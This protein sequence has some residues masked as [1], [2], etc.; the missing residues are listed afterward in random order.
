MWLSPV[1]A[2]LKNIRPAFRLGPN[3]DSW[4]KP[5]ITLKGILM[6]KNKPHLLIED[7]VARLIERGLVVKDVN[8]A[9]G[10]LS[11]IGYYRLNGYWH[12]FY[13]SDVGADGRKIVT[14]LFIPGV[15]FDQI[16]DIYKFDEE[17]RLLVFKGVSQIEVAIRAALAYEVGSS[18]PYG[19]SDVVNFRNNFKDFDR[20]S[21]AINA[22]VQKSKEPYIRHHL[23]NYQGQIPIWA[24]IEIFSFENLSAYFRGLTQ[25]QRNDVAGRLNLFDRSGTGYGAALLNWI[26][27]IV[28]IRNTCAHH[29][30]LWN[31]NISHQLKQTHFRHFPETLHIRDHQAYASRMGWTRPTHSTDRIYSSLVIMGMLLEHIEPTSNWKMDIKNLYL[32]LPLNHSVYESGFP[33]GWQS[34]QYWR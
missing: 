24:L 33:D 20:L 15:T 3:W 9:A 14:D 11:K 21:A 30:R 5:V 1:G 19:M 31:K 13:M 28:E 18:N 8:Y 34:E 32:R 25:K 29:S 2:N 27:N 7:Q 17:L 16:I 22:R 10:A 26:Q 23:D 4:G 12:Q 6:G